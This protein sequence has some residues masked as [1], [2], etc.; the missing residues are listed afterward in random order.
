MEIEGKNT[1][2][3]CEFHKLCKAE[4]F[5]FECWFNILQG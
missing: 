3:E 5:R 4:L 2:I 1:T